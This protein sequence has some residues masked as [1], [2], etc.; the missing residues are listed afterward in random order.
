M[1]NES[2][3]ECEYQIA[4]PLWMCLHPTVANYE[5]DKNTTSILQQLDKET[6]FLKDSRFSFCVISQMMLF[7][8]L[9]GQKESPTTYTWLTITSELLYGEKKQICLDSSNWPIFHLCSPEIYS[10]ARLYLQLALFSCFLSFIIVLQVIARRL[11]ESKQNTP[12]LYLSSGFEMSI[13]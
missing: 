8:C 6:L 7:S 12:H 10:K 9:M 5:E 11:L 13:N 1:T 3:S 2:S 4:N